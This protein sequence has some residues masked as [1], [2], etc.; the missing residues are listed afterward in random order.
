MGVHSLEF[1]M[2]EGFKV[3][4]SKLSDDSSTTR[5]LG[6]LF[7]LDPKVSKIRKAPSVPH[8][9]DLLCAK[10]DGP[11]PITPSELRNSD[12]LREQNYRFIMTGSSLKKSP[13]FKAFLLEIRGR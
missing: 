10:P 4:R 3:P 13:G 12:S 6:H 11:G 7:K 1:F 9:D 2:S 8:G 5:T